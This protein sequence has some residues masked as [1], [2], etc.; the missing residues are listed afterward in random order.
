MGETL[1]DGAPTLAQLTAHV[2]AA[3]GGAALGGADAR[4][5]AEALLV[6]ALAIGRATLLAHPERRIGG[7]ALAR[8]R[9]WT[10]RRARGEPLAYLAGMREFWSL[11]F[12]VTPDVLVPRPET[13]EL[14][15]CALALGDGFDALGSGSGAP[16]RVPA[17]AD[18]GTGSGC[19]A[20]AIA[21]ERAHW[22]ICATDASPAALAVARGNARALGLAHVEFLEGSWY[23]PLAGRFFDLI[24]SNPPYVAADDAALDDPALRHEPRLALTPG[25]DALAALRRIVDGAAAHLRP[26]GALAL[27][28]GADQAR[29]VA[30]LLVARGFAHVRCAPDLAG[31]DRVTCGILP[32]ATTGPP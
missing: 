15:R 20:L 2:A 23:E 30:A 14:V 12:T 7:E 22:H 21:S 5:E 32:S 31:H 18:L 29:A 8:V 6:A 9:D 10:T 1:T 17:V 19:V 11:P 4:R 25:H 3:L 16:D 24:V 28:H 26:G 13:E 27:E